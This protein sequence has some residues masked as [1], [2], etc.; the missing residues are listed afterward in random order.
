VVS[1]KR[2]KKMPETKLAIMLDAKHGP[3]L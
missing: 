1:G 2:L 3:I